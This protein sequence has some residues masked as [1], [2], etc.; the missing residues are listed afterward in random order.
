LHFGWIDSKPNMLNVI[1]LKRLRLLWALLKSLPLIYVYVVLFTSKLFLR[2]VKR[3]I[4]ESNTKDE[5][6][7]PV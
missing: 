7:F 6:P 5:Y 2:P 3:S 1:K 4:L